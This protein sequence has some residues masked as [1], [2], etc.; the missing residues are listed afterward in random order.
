[1]ISEFVASS[2]TLGSVLAAWNL[3]GILSLPPLH[4]V[5][6]SVCLSLC[7]NK[8]TE[9][10]LKNYKSDASIVIKIGFQ[11]WRNPLKTP[12]KVQNGL[13]LSVLCITFKNS[14]LLFFVYMTNT[15]SYNS[16]LYECLSIFWNIL[17]KRFIDYILL[18]LFLFFSRREKKQILLLYVLIEI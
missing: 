17:W 6:L 3:L 4:S 2:P 1:M 13:L 5:C 16:Y 9:I 7:Q 10:F 8:Q 15:H 14:Q 11:G 12:C 18:F